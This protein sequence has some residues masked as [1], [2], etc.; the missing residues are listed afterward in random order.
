M[1]DDIVGDIDIE[2]VDDGV[3]GP[4]TSTVSRASDTDGLDMSY[5]GRCE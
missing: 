1:M 3:D 5:K 2:R 4:T